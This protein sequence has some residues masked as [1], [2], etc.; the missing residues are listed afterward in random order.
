MKFSYTTKILTMITLLLVAACSST[1]DKYLYDNVGFDPEMSNRPNRTYSAP[2]SG[3]AMSPQQSS[4]YYYRQPTYTAPYT[5]PYPMQYAPPASRLYDNPYAMPP[6][7]YYPYYEADRYYV[8]PSYYGVNGY[9]QRSSSGNGG[10]I[11]NDNGS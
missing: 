11:P 2:T 9:D 1:G 10:R 6:A 7:N 4:G 5:Q 8:P 3:G